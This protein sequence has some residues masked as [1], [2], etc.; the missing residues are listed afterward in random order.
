MTTEDCQRF[1]NNLSSEDNWRCRKILNDFKTGPMIQEDS[2]PILSI[3]TKIIL[4]AKKIGCLIGFQAIT[5][6]I[7]S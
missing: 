7:V 3:I 4:F 2:Q 1:L 6:A 5:L